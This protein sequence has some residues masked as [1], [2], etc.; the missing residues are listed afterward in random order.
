ME[1]YLIEYCAPT[2]AGLKCGNIFTLKYN[3]VDNTD[4]FDEIDSLN[5]ILNEKGVYAHI[6]AFKETSVLIYVYRKKKLSLK[7]QQKSAQEILENKSYNFQK[8][9]YNLDLSEVLSHLSSRFEKNTEFPHEIGIF[10][11][12]PEHDVLGFIEN[13]GKNCLC[14]D[15]WKIYAD[16]DCAKKTCKNYRIC[17]NAYKTSF[18]K[19]RTIKQLTVAV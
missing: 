4:I 14:S 12:Y 13:K 5:K 10:L 18:L 19:G 1:K 17:K 8:F 16:V 3:K 2:L 6:L 9:N 11:D 15:I 7:L